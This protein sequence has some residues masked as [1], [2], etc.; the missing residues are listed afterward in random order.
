MTARIYL[1]TPPNIPD[2]VA[3]GERLTGILATGHVAAVQL[4]L[5][6]DLLDEQILEATKYILPI[7]HNHNVPLIL[8]DRYDLVQKSGADGVHLGQSDGGVRAVRAK[9]GPDKTIG[10]TCHN[11]RDLAIQAGMDGADYVAFGAFY[12]STTKD[13]KY[14]ATPETLRWAQDVLQLSCV[15]IGGVTA[16]NASTLITAGADM[17]AVCGAIWSAADPVAATCA[18]ADVCASEVADA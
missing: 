18:I 6:G 11:S 8:N 3:F 17:V 14:V 1:I 15:A 10:V 16:D 4:R 9:F 12:S 13:T 7:V 5:K 2:R